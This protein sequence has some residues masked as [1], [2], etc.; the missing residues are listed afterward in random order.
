MVCAATTHKQPVCAVFQR[1][2]VLLL[3]DQEAVAVG[4]QQLCQ[5]FLKD[6][7]P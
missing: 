6:I 1:V 5:Y 2:R 7:A 4:I 3:G